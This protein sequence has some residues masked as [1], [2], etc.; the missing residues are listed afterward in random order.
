M[1]CIPSSSSKKVYCFPDSEP[2]RG[3]A[4]IWAGQP[5]LPAP[6]PV[7]A[8]YGIWL[9]L[10]QDLTGARPGQPRL[11]AWA[12]TNPARGPVR[13]M[14][15]QM[16]TRFEDCCPLLPIRIPGK[17]RLGFIWAGAGL[18]RAN[19][20]PARTGPGRDSCGLKL[21]RLVVLIPWADP[22]PAR[23][24]PGWESTGLALA[25]TNPVVPRVA[26]TNPAWDQSGLAI[27]EL[28]V[29]V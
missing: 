18:P 7:W 17:S 10:L 12:R 29:M 14:P 2:G 8:T 15:G 6:S 9:G 27:W 23:A 4:G 16:W 22:G 5:S 25:Q 13:D 21:G 1:Y 20:G 28:F 11:P 3:P 19:P 24:G 26:R